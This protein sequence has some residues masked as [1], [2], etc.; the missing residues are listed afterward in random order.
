LKVAFGNEVGLIAKALQID[1]HKLMDIF[2]QDTKLNISKA[3]LRPGFAFGGSCLPKDLRALNFLSRNLDLSLPVLNHVLDS[4]RMIVERGA[5]WLLAQSKRRIAFLGISFKSGTDDV[6]ESP[7]VDLIER[8]LGKGCQVRI[9]DPNVQLA[10]LVGA[11][12]DY[13]TRVLPHITELMVSDIEEAIDWAEVIVVT[14]PNPAFAA[15]LR[16]VRPEQTV[17]DFAR[18]DLADNSRAKPQG[19]LW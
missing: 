7:F 19:F 6:R 2:F 10:R 1:S 3:Y 18:L 11:N 16:A 15:G 12:K 8:V 17:L 13:L 5:S 4:N 9:F 14:T